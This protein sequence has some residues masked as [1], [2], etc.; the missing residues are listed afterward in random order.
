MSLLILY[1]F[2]DSSLTLARQCNIRFGI[3][4]HGLFRHLVGRRMLGVGCSGWNLSVGGGRRSGHNSQSTARYRDC[5]DR[6][7]EAR[8]QTLPCHPPCWT[9]GNRDSKTESRKSSERGLEESQTSG[10]LKTRR[11]GLQRSLHILYIG[12]IHT[13]EHLA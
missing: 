11:L 9:L 1:P 7:C 5:A 3:C 12:S 2:C 10:V 6:R 13:T 8:K 4:G